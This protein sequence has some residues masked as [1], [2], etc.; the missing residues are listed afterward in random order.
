MDRV[1]IHYIGVTRSLPAFTFRGEMGDDGGKD[2]E[3]SISLLA[4]CS[5]DFNMVLSRDTPPT[6]D[7][8]WLVLDLSR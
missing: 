1:F 2:L 4:C 5:L 7:M 3:E 6:Y 8:V